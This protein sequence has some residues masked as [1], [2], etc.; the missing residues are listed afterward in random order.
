MNM[1]S[2]CTIAMTAVIGMAW[3]L[4]F[5]LCLSARRADE[6]AA[7]HFSSINSRL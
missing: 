3:I 1:T 6:I 5:G 7:R 2:L 4:C